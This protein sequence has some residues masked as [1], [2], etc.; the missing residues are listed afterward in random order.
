M[1]ATVHALSINSLVGIS[2]YFIYPSLHFTGI[3]LQESDH[4]GNWL[5]RVLFE[6]AMGMKLSTDYQNGRICLSALH[7]S[8]GNS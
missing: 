2:V 4:D 1:L 6:N 3:D 7:E 5:I 8:S